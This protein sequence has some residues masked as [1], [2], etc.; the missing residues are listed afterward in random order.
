MDRG[1]VDCLWVEV[2]AYWIPL[3]LGGDCTFFEE[4]VPYASVRRV[5]L[6]PLVRNFGDERSGRLLFIFFKFLLFDDVILV[7][8]LY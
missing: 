2:P 8:F 5:S 7:T 3:Y 1:L 6:G 4:P